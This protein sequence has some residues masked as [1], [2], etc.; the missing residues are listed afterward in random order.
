MSD[1]FEMLIKIVSIYADIRSM[2]VSNISSLMSLIVQ[3]TIE[4]QE[5]LVKVALKTD[6]EASKEAL[7]SEAVGQQGI[8]FYA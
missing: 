2:D 4:F 1:L 5:K 3:E 6:V 7:V 8:D